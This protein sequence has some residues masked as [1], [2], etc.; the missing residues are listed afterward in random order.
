MSFKKIINFSFLLVV[1]VQ[2]WAQEPKNVRVIEAKDIPVDTTQTA[3]ELVS[4][5]NILINSDSTDYNTSIDFNQTL[6]PVIQVPIFNLQDDP[7]TASVDAKWMDLLRNYD[8]F[9]S[10]AM[11]VKDLPGEN[12]V[13]EDLPTDVLKQRLAEIDARTPFNVTYNPELERIIKSFLKNRGKA[14]S[15]LMAKSK[16]YFPIFEEYLENYDVP[17]ETKYLAIVESALQP[18]AR[19]RAGASGLWQF[20][21]GT[22]KQY[23]L[24]VSSYVDERQNPRRSSEAAAKHLSDLYDI[25][26]DWDLALAAYNSGA[27]NVNKAIRRSGGKRNYWN[28]RPYLP[29]ETANYVPIFYATLYLFE[30]G[31]LHNIYPDSQFNLK[32]YETDTIQVKRQISFEQIQTTTGIDISLLEFLNPSY[33]INVIPYSDTKNYELVLPREFVGIFVQNEDKIYEYVASME[34]LR[35]SPALQN[36]ENNNYDER[37]NMATAVHR[38]KRGEVLGK[39][40]DKY[41]VSVK[42]LMKWNHLKSSKVFVGQKIKIHKNSQENSDA[43]EE[44]TSTQETNN[45]KSSETSSHRSTDKYVTY[46]VKHGDTLWSI[47]NKFPNVS[48]DEIKKWNKI[49]GNKLVV[50]KKLKIYKG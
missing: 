48:V 45:Q 47:A 6:I 49:D 28:L 3:S 2:L 30:Y 11:L 16:Y 12:V 7:Y 21:Y 19:S 5:D 20:M 46:T 36:V 42:Q 37:T 43:N 35:E 34:A 22:G 18:K 39:I 9:D 13:I 17:I 33:K 15:N 38:V 26:E 27:G 31:H 8:Q 40:A 4:I 32:S 1:T 10:S 44:V 24:D 50:G 14:I 25:F 41:N 29:R 23:G